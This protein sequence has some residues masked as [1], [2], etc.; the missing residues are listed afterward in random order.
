MGAHGR[1][2]Q[3]RCHAALNPAPRSTPRRCRSIAALAARPVALRLNVTRVPPQHAPSMKLTVRPWSMGEWL[4]ARMPAVVAMNSPDRS[5]GR[6]SISLPCRWSPEIPD[7]WDRQR[8]PSRHVSHRPWGP[9]EQEMPWSVHSPT[10]AARISAV[11]PAW[12]SASWSAANARLRRPSP[13]RRGPWRRCRSGRRALLRAR[14][15]EAARRRCCGRL[16]LLAG[17][18]PRGVRGRRAQARGFQGLR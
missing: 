15:G 18:A 8:L 14:A 12:T 9:L 2:G 11:E 5:A 4:T 13:P 10:A 3:G 1:T 17:R 16:G 7:T 6:R